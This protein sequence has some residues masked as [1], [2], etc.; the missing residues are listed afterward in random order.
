M[1]VIDDDPDISRALALRLEGYGI[2]V[3]RAFNGL[4]GF[5]TGLER[6]PDLIITDMNM[7]NGEGNYIFGRFKSHPLTQNIPVI[8]LTGQDNP[9][10]KRLML[11]LGVNA[12]FQK[13]IVFEELLHQLRQHLELP[14]AP[15]RRG[16][17]STHCVR[18]S[19]L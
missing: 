14:A 12:Y 10:L 13:P 18:A 5:W 8:V 7:P 11:S 6:L 2:E 3:I 16:E 4:E 15:G 1:L 17:E 19:A 9:G